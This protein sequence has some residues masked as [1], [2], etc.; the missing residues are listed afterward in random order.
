[1]LKFTEKTVF[2]VITEKKLWKSIPQLLR[3]LSFRS[4][5]P[6]DYHLP[7]KTPKKN[8]FLFFQN[9]LISTNKPTNLINYLSN[10]TPLPA[11]RRKSA[12]S[13]KSFPL[14]RPQD[15][16]LNWVGA[17]PA[18][19]KAKATMASVCFGLVLP[20]ENKTHSKKQMRRNVIAANKQV[21][22]FGT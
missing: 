12:S 1:M 3:C 7:P 16:S 5:V 15:Q 14:S 9:L 18:A 4:S 6:P 19:P 2:Q 11:R 8:T 17:I 21:C 20:W 13:W 10:G 22:C